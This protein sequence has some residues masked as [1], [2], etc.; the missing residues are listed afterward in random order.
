MNSDIIAAVGL[1]I[2]LSMWSYCFHA[3][4]TYRDRERE[5]KREYYDEGGDVMIFITGSN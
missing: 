2:K 3:L 1:S 5:S 4:C